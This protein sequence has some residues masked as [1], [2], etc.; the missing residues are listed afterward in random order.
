MNMSDEK[1]NN[2]RK[3]MDA[4]MAEI[5]SDMLDDEDIKN[6]RKVVRN[7]LTRAEAGTTL[8]YI[9]AFFEGFKYGVSTVSQSSEMGAP[10]MS[11][12]A[13]IIV[14]DQSKVDAKVKETKTAG[15]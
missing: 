6:L 5:A 2:M 11:G 14:E 12:L 15:A 3:K 1:A 10:V 7:S 4:F 8:P 13:R 9:K